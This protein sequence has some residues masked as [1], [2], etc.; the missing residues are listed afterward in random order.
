MEE[1]KNEKTQTNS[2]TAVAEEVEVAQ[3]GQVSLGK[4]KDVKALIHAYNS[5]QAEF[6]KRCQRIKELEGTAKVIDNASC[7]IA[8]AVVEQEENSS[9]I[10]NEERENILKDYLKDVLSSK[11]KAILMDG[12]G[13][14]VKT[15]KMRPKTFQEAS[16]LA[17]EILL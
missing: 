2:D 13:V 8:K 6:T 12:V 14:G 7:T 10:T 1:L 15:P 5:L 11:Q 3:D 4:F 9:G 16:A 17:K